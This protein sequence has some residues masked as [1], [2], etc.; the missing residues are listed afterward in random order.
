MKVS[1]NVIR[2]LLPLYAEKLT[3]PDSNQLVEEHLT[4]CPECTRQ[5]SVMQKTAPIPVEAD[6]DA[7]EKIRRV[8]RKRWMLTALTAVLLVVT[9]VCQGVLLLDATVYLTPEQAVESVEV[10]ENGDLFIRATGYV[11][12]YAATSMGESEDA[13]GIVA[14]SNLQKLWFGSRENSIVPYEELPELVKYDMSEEDYHFASGMTIPAG[15]KTV[16]YCDGNTG[17]ADTLLWGEGEIPQRPILAVEHEFVMYHAL[18]L[19]LAV[20]CGMA[21]YLLRKKRFASVGIYLAMAFASV[22]VSTFV[23]SAGQLVSR[24]GEFTEHVLEGITVAPLMFFT[25]VC[26]YQLYRLV[27]KD[28]IV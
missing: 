26:G 7:L 6:T 4:D 18:L 14:T 5:L 25:L 28:R 24:Y 16:W 8:M 12:G 21:A 1:C 13:W 27:K 22:S 19:T 9:I 20:L 2:D 17:K 15:V 23:V 3:S 10:K 11:N